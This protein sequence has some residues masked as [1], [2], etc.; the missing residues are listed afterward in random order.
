[1]KR[2]I[3]FIATNLAIMLVLGF[4]TS[5]L[6]VNQ[7]LTANG[8]NLTSLL[9]FSGIIGFGGAFISLWMSKPIAKWST[10]AQVIATPRNGTEQWLVE[11]VTRLAQKAGIAMPEVAVYEGD[12]NAFA[13]GA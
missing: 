5:I 4:T 11:T 13:T 2:I 3:L 10:G 7:Y 8:L 6:G 1:M 12:P 9:I